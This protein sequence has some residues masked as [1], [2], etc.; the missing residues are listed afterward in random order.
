MNITSLSQNKK[1]LEFILNMIDLKFDFI[2]ITESKIKT[3]N[4]AYNIDIDGCQYFSTPTEA[5]KGGAILYI[6]AKSRPKLDKM[7]YKSDYLGSV[8]LKFVIISCIYRQPS[9]DVRE[10]NGEYLNPLM[11]TLG[12][13]DKK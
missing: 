1:E 2:G 7:M 4:P 9:M 8:F 10:F 3:T 5:D 6:N 13:E 11:E 12:A